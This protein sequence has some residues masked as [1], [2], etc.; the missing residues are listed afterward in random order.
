MKFGHFQ[1]KKS[2]WSKNSHFWEFSKFAIFQCFTQTPKCVFLDRNGNRNRIH[3]RNRNAKTATYKSLAEI[4][5][6][7]FQHRFCSLCCKFWL[8]HG[9]LIFVHQ[10]YTLIFWQIFQ[11][12]TKIQ[13]YISSYSLKE[14]IIIRS[15]NLC[16]DEQKSSHCFKNEHFEWKQK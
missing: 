15:V 16:F 1:G 14:F 13:F 5:D 12:E 3:N 4:R 9:M 2:I 7:I 6:L 11:Q 10:M 8:Y